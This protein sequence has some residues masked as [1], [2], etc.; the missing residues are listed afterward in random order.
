M[1]SYN[2]RAW[3]QKTLYN[4]SRFSMKQNGSAWCYITLDPDQQETLYHRNRIGMKSYNARAWSQKILYNESR[5]SIIVYNTGSLSA[6]DVIAD[7]PDQHDD[8]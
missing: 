5:F 7:E 4:E 3:S 6:G 2:A 1:K 8:L